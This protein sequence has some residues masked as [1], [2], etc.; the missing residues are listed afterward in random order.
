LTRLHQA[1]TLKGEAPRGSAGRKFA[2]RQQSNS[3]SQGWCESV[4]G[5]G[6][7]LL[8]ELLRPQRGPEHRQKSRVHGQTILSLH[9]NLTAPPEGGA[10]NGMAT[11]DERGGIS[12]WRPRAVR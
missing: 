12:R 6:S 11:P 4:S 1:T 10:A 8:R 7:R 3:H 9:F 5:P 2:S